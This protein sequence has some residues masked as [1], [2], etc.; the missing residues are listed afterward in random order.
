VPGHGARPAVRLWRLTRKILGA[1][2]TPICWHAGSLA[3]ASGTVGAAGKSAG[4]GG[5]MLVYRA[6]VATFLGGGL[7]SG[8]VAGRGTPGTV[9]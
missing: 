7:F 4:F 5:G 8:R 9:A 3:R 1:R 6:R 2:S